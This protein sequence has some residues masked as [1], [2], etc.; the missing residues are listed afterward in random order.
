MAA[1]PCLAADLPTF[2]ENG[3]RRSGAVAAAYFKIPLGGGTKAGKGQAGVRM[4]VVHDYRAAGLLSARVVS[5]DSFDLRLAGERK[6]ALYVGGRKVD[7]ETRS[8][9]RGPAGTIVTV[10]VIAAAAVGGFYLARAISDSGG[11]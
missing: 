9:F 2:A 10:V 1:S 4:S 5:A 6:P 8:N 3:E 7:G 11:E